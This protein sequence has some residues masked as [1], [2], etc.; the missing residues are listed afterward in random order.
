M[1]WSLKQS[2]SLN[3]MFLKVLYENTAAVF[4]MKHLL[5]SELWKFLSEITTVTD[6]VAEG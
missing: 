1:N 5:M 2:S 6:P 3:G 4:V